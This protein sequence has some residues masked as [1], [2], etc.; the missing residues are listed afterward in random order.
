MIVPSH[1]FKESILQ[2]AIELGNQYVHICTNSVVDK[3][4]MIRIG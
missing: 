4:I 2:L 1:S 3:V